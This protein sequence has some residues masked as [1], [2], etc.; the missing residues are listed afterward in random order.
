MKTG[1]AEIKVMNAASVGHVH[2]GVRKERWVAFEGSALSP[3]TSMERQPGAENLRVYKDG[4]GRGLTD[5]R[6][7]TVEADA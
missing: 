4:D 6:S 1:V 7:T 5:K 2:S 3:V